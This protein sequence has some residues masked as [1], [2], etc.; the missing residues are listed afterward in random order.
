MPAEEAAEPAFIFLADAQGGFGL[1]G[2]MPGRVER[3]MVFLDTDV[4][5][6][7]I[8]VGD[9]GVFAGGFAFKRHLKGL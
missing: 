3:G 8:V 1:V 4:G 5:G 2:N 7:A 6:D 9:R